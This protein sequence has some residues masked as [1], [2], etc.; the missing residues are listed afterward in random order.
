MISARRLL[1]APLN[2]EFDLPRDKA[3]HLR[4]PG[5][6]L[7]GTYLPSDRSF[8]YAVEFDTLDEDTR[9]ALL[10]F[11]SREQQRAIRSGDGYP[12]PAAEE[13]N[14]QRAH[15]RVDVDQVIRIAITGI[16]APVEAVLLDVSTGGARV[17]VEHVL[18][19][20]WELTLRFS[21]GNG[22][23]VKMHARALPG[24]KEQRRRYVQ[25]LIWV[26]PDPE[27]TREVDRFIRGN[28]AKGQ[29]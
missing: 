25:S 13:S 5:K 10:R 3:P 18:R 14:E 27:V 16:A 17:S 9:E 15:R 28:N 11:I 7:K 29:G 19:Q 26:D 6:I 8:K 24:V 21:L 22:S 4:L 12:P 20:E 23:E 1:R 2:V